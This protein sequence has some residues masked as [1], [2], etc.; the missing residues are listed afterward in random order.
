MPTVTVATNTRR[1][2]NPRVVVVVLDGVVFVCPL[3]DDPTKKTTSS[4]FLPYAVV[5]IPDR[6]DDDD[7]TVMEG[8]LVEKI[9]DLRWLFLRLAGG[10]C[11]SF[12]GLH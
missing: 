7:G 12:Q 2:A 9:N 8:W 4:S 3:D 6:N 1:L 11:R 10:R 5:D